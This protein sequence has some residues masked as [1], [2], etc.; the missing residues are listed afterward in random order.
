MDASHAS[1]RDDFEV[2]GEVLDAMVATARS[3]PGCLGA[4]MTGA[5]FGGCAIALVAAAAAERFAGDAARRYRDATGVEARAY[6]CRAADGA[7]VARVTP[8]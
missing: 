1:L 2:T 7:G 4:R 5:G 6:R 8:P 3:L